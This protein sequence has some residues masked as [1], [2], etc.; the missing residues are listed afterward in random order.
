MDPR[1]RVAVSYMRAELNKEMSFEHMARR[2]NLS[3]SRLSHLFKEE[4]GIAPTKYLKLMRMERARELIG[5]TFLSIKEIAAAAGFNDCSH[6]VRNYKRSFGM[7][8]TQ[9]RAYAGLQIEE[10]TVPGGR[11]DKR[12]DRQIPGKSRTSNEVTAINRK[13]LAS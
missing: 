3:T 2:V 6:F 1:V 5:S 4:F 8:P 13:A 10:E 7:T 11:A 9:Y 12:N